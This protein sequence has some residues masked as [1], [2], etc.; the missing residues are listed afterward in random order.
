VMSEASNTARIHFI[1]WWR[2]P[3]W[4]WGYDK[5]YGYDSTFYAIGFGKFSLQLERPGK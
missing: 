1:Q 4:V 2:N 3:R 5:F